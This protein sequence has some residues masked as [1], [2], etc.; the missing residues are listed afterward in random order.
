MT[1]FLTG[2]LICNKTTKSKPCSLSY[3]ITK[4]LNAMCVEIQNRHGYGPTL[5]SLNGK[6]KHIRFFI[7][8]G[9]TD[10]TE[11]LPRLIPGFHLSCAMRKPVFLHLQKQ[12]C[13]S[14]AWLPCPYVQPLF[15]L[16]K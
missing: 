12:R 9:Q 1:S 15:S 3:D 14:A 8:A 4:P 5:I 10:Q 7:N 16:H 13:R 11:Q 6:L 2:L